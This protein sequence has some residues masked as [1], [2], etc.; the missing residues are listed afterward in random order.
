[1]NPG[2][3]EVCDDGIDQDCDP[4]PSACRATGSNSL[5]THDA[6]LTGFIALGYV[7][8]GHDVGDVTGDGVRDLL[9]LCPNPW[10][11]LPVVPAARL[12][13]GPVSGDASLSTAWTTFT[14]ASTDLGSSG[15]GEI[16]F[17]RDGNND[18]LLGTEYV[19]DDSGS[20]DTVY[21]FRGPVSAGTTSA[22]SADLTITALGSIG[23]FG[24]SFA[25]ADTDGDGF[26]DL[27]LGAGLLGSGGYPGGAYLF[28]GALS[29]AMTSLDATGT[30]LS[31]A[32][33]AAG[34]VVASPGDVDGDGLDDL[35]LGAPRQNSSSTYPGPGQAYLFLSPVSGT[36][37]TSDAD[38]TFV[39]ETDEDEAGFGLS[40][41]GDQ[42]GDGLPDLLVGAPYY[43]G[44]GQ[45]YGSAYLI[46]G[47]TRGTLS[48]ADAGTIFRG[49]AR[50]DEVGWS[51]ADG[52]ADGDGQADLGVGAYDHT[53]TRTSDGV[54]YLFYGP[55]ASG[56]LSTSL[57]ADASFH[58]EMESDR[59]GYGVSFGDLDEDGLS[60]LIIAALFGNEEVAYGGA[61]YVVRGH[62]E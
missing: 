55:V 41:A 40:G 32:D 11:Y 57:S 59:A 12:M 53:T 36:M 38:A 62:G 29:G 45:Y 15:A 21:G 49:D 27:V 16:D 50:Y 25:R 2:A 60:D 43:G 8:E 9:V 39:G 4:D 37:L 30:V 20:S 17:D 42:D 44:L 7:S 26:E 61:V 1:M 46:P 3:V 23:S 10:G 48:L 14:D 51:L 6:R 28:T 54:V 35:L 47:A 18:V 13:P 22:S 52:D 33:D 34:R 5:A 24:T 19:D 58:G 56:T 31:D